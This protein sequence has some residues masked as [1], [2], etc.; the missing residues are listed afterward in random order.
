MTAVTVKIPIIFLIIKKTPMNSITLTQHDTVVTWE[1]STD[2]LNTLLSELADDIAYG[3]LP[4][5]KS[6][7]RVKIVSEIIGIIIN[8][9]VDE[10][11]FQTVK[12]YIRS[13][14]FPKVIKKRGRPKKEQ[15]Y[16]TTAD[17]IEE[18]GICGG[19]VK[20]HPLGS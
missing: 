9:P 6:K 12:E 14:G 11:C 8:C 13:K 19:D 2:E 4:R 7:F 10:I 15:F 20:W 16:Y 17:D 1:L 18:A 5:G 3:R